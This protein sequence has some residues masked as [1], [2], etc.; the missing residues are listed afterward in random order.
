MFE[1]LGKKNSAVFHKWYTLDIEGRK[2]WWVRCIFE[3]DVP[4]AT[5]LYESQ[6]MGLV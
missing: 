2:G 1:I 6:C 4:V 5:D 3:D